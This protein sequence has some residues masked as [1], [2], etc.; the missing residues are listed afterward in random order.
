[1]WMCA[2][3][4]RV[5]AVHK[6][7]ARGAGRQRGALEATAELERAPRHGQRRRDRLDVV[8]RAA[9]LPA[10]HAV[11]RR[12]KFVPGGDRLRERHLEALQVVVE[13][14][15]LRCLRGHSSRIW[16]AAT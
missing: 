3:T 6:H 13:G 16:K 2:R 1:M 8:Q 11:A 7:L 14:A 10:G 5:L 9:H 4:V 15:Q 12:G